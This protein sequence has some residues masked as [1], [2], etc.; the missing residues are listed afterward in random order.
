MPTSN[1]VP[2]ARQIEIVLLFTAFIAATY[3]FGVYLFPAIVEPIRAELGFSYAALAT[4]SGLVQ[5]GFMVTA[6]VA[7]V[8]TLRFGAMPLILGACLTCALALLGL[9]FVGGIWS[10]GALLVLLGS[11]A[12]VVWVPMV[13]VSRA[14]IAPAHQGKALGLMS[15]GTSY[16][17]FV[18]SFLMVT[19]LPQ[20][21]WRW[22]WGVTGLAVLVLA[23]VAVI[24]LRGPGL[25][26]GRATETG[27]QAEGV[28]TKTSVLSPV[29]G[30]LV[31]VMFLNGL[32]CMPF[33]T[34][35]S[36]YLQ[37]E[38]A[39]P[40]AETALVWRLV[41]I[42]GMIGGFAVGALADK[43]TVRR[44]MILMQLVL[45]GACL[46]LISPQPM[47][48]AAMRI[49]AAIGFGTAFAAI[50]GLVPAYVSL[51]FGKGQA[52]MVFSL[53]NI[54]LGLGGIG[55]NLA[56]G[57]VKEVSG[58]F[59]GSYAAMAVAATVAA[60]LCLL[61]PVPGSRFS[62]LVDAA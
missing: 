31:G 23:T 9:A 58:S 7:G 47:A 22:I 49:A 35:L 42:L 38:L 50:F 6:I 54:A 44:A 20:F 12:V 48:G 5:A 62:G 43:I 13:E 10:M 4:I 29:S 3:G 37:G 46:A 11:C 61:L 40:Q 8:L 45:A 18:N 24:R 52:A 26:S 32:A 39:L 2:A 41:G 27:S 21:G 60:G 36:A 25:K 53:T 14:V 16:G 56:G 34:Y 1:P 30:L 28:P 59:V 57:L 55:G 17:V 51:A 15:S 33:Q 19:V